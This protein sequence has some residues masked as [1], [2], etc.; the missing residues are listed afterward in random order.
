MRNSSAVNPHELTCTNC[1]KSNH[2]IEIGDIVV[3]GDDRQTQ[4][5]RCRKC[6]IDAT[7]VVGTDLGNIG[8]IYAVDG[9]L[10]S[11]R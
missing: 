10:E 11:R 8:E 2:N 7:V 6:D 3:E 1:G 4:K 9:D 5:A